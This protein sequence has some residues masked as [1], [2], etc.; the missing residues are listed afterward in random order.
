MLLMKKVPWERWGLIDRGA[1]P[2]KKHQ[3]CLLS[4]HLTYQ[5]VEEDGKGRSYLFDCVSAFVRPGT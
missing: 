4:I 5:K 1:P 2:P 3:S